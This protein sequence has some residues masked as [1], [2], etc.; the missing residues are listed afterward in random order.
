MTPKLACVVYAI[1][2]YKYQKTQAVQVQT[3]SDCHGDTLKNPFIKAGANT[4]DVKT[5]NL[6]QYTWFHCKW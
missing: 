6:T 2:K 1:T 5:H 4:A 3:V